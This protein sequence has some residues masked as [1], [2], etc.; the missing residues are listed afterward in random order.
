[1]QLPNT[2]FLE[3]F[4]IKDPR[5][6]LRSPNPKEGDPRNPLMPVEDPNTGTS[7]ASLTMPAAEKYS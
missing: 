7:R 5:L 2:I 4:K 1:M 3:N 6:Y